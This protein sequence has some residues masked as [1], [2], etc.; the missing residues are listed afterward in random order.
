M[1]RPKGYSSCAVFLAHFG[2]ELRECM[3]KKKKEICGFE[4]DFNNYFLLPFLI[5]D[6]IISQRP[7]LNSGC[8]KWHFLVWNRVNSEEAG[9]TLTR[10]PSSTPPGFNTLKDCFNVGKEIENMC[11]RTSVIF[12]VR[13]NN[14]LAQIYRALTYSIDSN[15]EV[16]TS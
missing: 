14:N 4:M 1:C 6:D 2:L 10:I 13:R 5:N 8:E 16:G 9:G 11:R 3:R 15:G 7:G 12:G